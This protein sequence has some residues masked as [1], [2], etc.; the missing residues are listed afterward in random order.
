MPT[1][2]LEPVT[3]TASGRGPVEEAVLAS[4]LSSHEPETYLWISLPLPGGGVRIRHA[5]TD[6]GAPLGD[7]VDQLA[8]AK[9]F[10]AAD[11][12]HI[13][14]RHSAVT[15]RGAIRIE[16]HPLRPILADVRDGVRAPQDRRDGI[17]RIL[18]CAGEMTGQ[19]PRPGIPRW[20][21][22][23]PALLAWTTR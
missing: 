21:G 6:L 19:T 1:L 10:D 5:W 18:E 14:D 2:T 11:W 7:R 23:G 20:V 4:I 9:G 17:R 3:R 13:T 15:F 8:L 22:V 12:L 16:A